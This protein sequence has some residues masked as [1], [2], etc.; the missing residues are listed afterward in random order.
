M[1]KLLCMVVLCLF[2]SAHSKIQAADAGHNLIAY[3]SEEAQE[4]DFLEPEDP[5]YTFSDLVTAS[6]QPICR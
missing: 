3:D 6:Q 5:R 1:N 2:L 4:K